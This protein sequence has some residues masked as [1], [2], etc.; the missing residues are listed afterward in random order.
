MLTDEEIRSARFQCRCSEGFGVSD[1]AATRLARFVADVQLAKIIKAGYLPVE[2]V[3]LEVLSD[4]E[5]AERIRHI[6]VGYYSIY[7]SEKS[8]ATHIGKI[9][10]DLIKEAG[11]KSP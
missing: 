2:P 7:A 1:D 5:T 6:V 10:L 3:Q 11:Y 9:L 4:E 8:E